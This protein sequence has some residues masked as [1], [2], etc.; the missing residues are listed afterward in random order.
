MPDWSSHEGPCRDGRY[1]DCYLCVN[2]TIEERDRYREAL[3]LIGNMGCIGTCAD[4]LK[5]YA[6]IAREAQNPKSEKQA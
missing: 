4:D 2:A 3:T 1:E 5:C 6:C